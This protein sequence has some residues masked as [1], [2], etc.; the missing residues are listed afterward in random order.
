[1]VWDSYNYMQMKKYKNRYIG[2]RHGISKANSENIVV[3]KIENGRSNYGLTQEGAKGVRHSIA[4]ALSSGMLNSE[5]LI[6]ASDFN[7]TYET[8]LIAEKMLNTKPIFVAPELRERSFG[9]FELHND[10][11]NCYKKIWDLDSRNPDHVTNGVESITSVAQRAYLLIEKLEKA[12]TGKTFLLI[13]HADT[14]HILRCVL[15]GTSITQHR[16]GKLFNNADIFYLC[17]S[18]L[19]T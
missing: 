19:N 2:M 12:F 7:R 1:M 17:N 5:V 13:S 11:V 3:S 16:S 18:T 8:A 9:E 14:L 10:A 4:K 15:S 6:Y